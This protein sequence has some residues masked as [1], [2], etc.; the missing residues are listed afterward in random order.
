M[1]PRPNP[2]WNRSAPSGTGTDHLNSITTNETWTATASP[3]RLPYDLIISAT[4]TI[5]PC[6]VVQIAEDKE[7]RIDQKGALIAA[8]RPGSAVTIE[9]KDT[10]AWRRILIQGGTLSLSHAVVRGGGYPGNTNPAL[11]GMLDMQ[12]SGGVLVN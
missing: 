11:F 1:R 10:K 2:N 5:E 4:L 7:I 9:R 8:G 12:S 3:H 6:A